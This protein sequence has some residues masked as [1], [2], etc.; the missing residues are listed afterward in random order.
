MT[1]YTDQYWMHKAL[2]LA[3]EG[4]SQ[5]EVPVGAVVVLE[6]QLIGQGWNQPVLSGD[7]T[8]HAEVIALRDAARS[9]ANYRLLNTTLYVT[10]E[11]CTMCAGALVH[12]RVKRLV[13]GALEPKAGVV[14]SNLSLF[15]KGFF[16]HSID[17]QGGVMAEES[18]ALMS[19]FFKQRRLL[20]KE[21]LVQSDKTAKY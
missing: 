4:A 10:I 19:N 16:N 2:K 17:V 21:R 13:Y 14:V 8:A 6:N 20:K 1:Q 18:S 12:A 7:P 15:D 5:G 11:P 3:E 9:V